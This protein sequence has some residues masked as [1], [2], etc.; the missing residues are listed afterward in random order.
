M[1]VCEYNDK[2][3]ILK[4]Y[5]LVLKFSWGLPGGFINKNE[6]PQK[7]LLEKCMKKQD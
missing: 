7:Q 1:V 2:I 4:E 3:L 5:K 6:K